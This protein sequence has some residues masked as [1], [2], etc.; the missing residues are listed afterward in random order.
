MRSKLLTLGIIFALTHSWAKDVGSTESGSKTS[1]LIP[2]GKYI[3]FFS[4]DTSK[5]KLNETNKKPIE[6]HSFW[7][8]R[9]PVTNRDYLKFIRGHPDWRKS[10]V[11]QVFSDPHYLENWSTDLRLRN[12]REWDGPATHVSW[13]A[14]QAYC[15]WLGKELPST[16]QWE[17]ALYDQGRN[18]DQ[19]RDRILK[20]YGNPNQKLLSPVRHTSQNGFGISDLVGVIWEWTL[21]FNSFMASPEARDSTGDKNLFCGGGSEGARNTSDYA[22]FMRY[23]FRSSL[24][25]AYSTSNLGFRCAKEVP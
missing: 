9:V 13:F 21:D 11:K 10:H 25:A 4:P 6:V 20:W 8:D 23:S 15:E 17:Y 24:K 18:Q 7:I 3:P 22:T 14:A 12:A 19:V 16:D 2:G 5:N 1:V